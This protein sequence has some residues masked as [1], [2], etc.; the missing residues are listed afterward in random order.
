MLIAAMGEEYPVLEYLYIATL[1]KQKTSLVLPR[2]LHAPQLRSLVLMNFAFPI[3]SPILST[4]TNIVT[5]LLQKIHP[6]AYF[7]PN[8]LLPRLSLLPQLETLGISF[9]TPVP[10]REVERHLLFTSMTTHVTLPS[11]RSFGFNG[12]SVYLEALPRSRLHSSRNSK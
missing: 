7:H 2:T 4:A 10:N 8:D 5:L 11:L 9:L 12:V 3:M 1:T 6:S